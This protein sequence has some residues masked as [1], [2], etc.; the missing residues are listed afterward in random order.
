MYQKLASKALKAYTTTKQV[1]S[2]LSIDTEVPLLLNEIS[3]YK[4]NNTKD[5][6]S[7]T[8]RKCIEFQV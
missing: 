4:K 7:D 5:K 6:T 2:N 1:S 8:H 3:L